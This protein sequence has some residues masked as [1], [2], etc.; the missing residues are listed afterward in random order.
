MAF[1]WS[2]ATK[3]D[4]L[5]CRGGV[6]RERGRTD[7]GDQNDIL[8]ERDGDLVHG[9]CIVLVEREDGCIGLPGLA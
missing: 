3:L 8:V 1:P 7:R 2:D 6:L 5:V 9:F 4:K